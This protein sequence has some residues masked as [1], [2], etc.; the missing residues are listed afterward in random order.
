MSDINREKC[1]FIE[2]ISMIDR[3]KAEKAFMD[4]ADNYDT[5]DV[6]IKSKIDHTLRVSE[7]AD[8]IAKSRYEG[9]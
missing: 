9:R 3:V 6:M 7:N 4:Y 1:A 8:R 5:S 2:E